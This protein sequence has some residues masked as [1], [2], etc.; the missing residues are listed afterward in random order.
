MW[1]NS[2]AFFRNRVT[3]WIH[4]KRK[5]IGVRSQVSE[6][7]LSVHFGPWH[8]LCTSGLHRRGSCG[9]HGAVATP[10]SFLNL[11]KGYL[12]VRSQERAPAARADS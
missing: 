10:L 7:V 11:R 4:G 2:E 8:S 5:G 6:E 3:D 12:V 1:A 9:E